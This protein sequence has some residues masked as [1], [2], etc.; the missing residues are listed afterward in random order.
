MQLGGTSHSFCTACRRRC[1][2]EGLRHMHLALGCVKV[3]ES[4]PEGP[5]EVPAERRREGSCEAPQTNQ[6]PDEGF[7]VASWL[8][9]GMQYLAA[10]AAGVRF[11]WSSQQTRP[12]CHASRLCF[13]FPAAKPHEFR[14]RWPYVRLPPLHE[15][16]YGSRATWRGEHAVF[17]CS[18]SEFRRLC[19]VC[20][21]TASS[22]MRIYR[23]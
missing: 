4:A 9:F 20:R 5:A 21:G 14:L 8:D 17:N 7:C 2:G 23:P 16:N 18:G 3:P 6:A 11:A 10:F 22:I 13:V 15:C 19:P 12:W 1:S